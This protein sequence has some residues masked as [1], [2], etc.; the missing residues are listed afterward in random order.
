MGVGGNPQFRCRAWQAQILD[1]IHCAQLQEQPWNACE[2]TGRWKASLTCQQFRCYSFC[3]FLHR[4]EVARPT[5]RLLR[6]PFWV[7]IQN[8]MH[9]AS[10]LKGT[11]AMSA[12]SLGVKMLAYLHSFNVILLS[13]LSHRCCSTRRLL[14]PPFWNQV[15]REAITS[16]KSNRTAI[17][18][19]CTG[20]ITKM[21]MIIII[22]TV[23]CHAN[24]HLYYVNGKTGKLD[25]VAP[26][27]TR[28]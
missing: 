10:L 6:P 3:C 7:Q 21:M 18:A 2:V 25:N 9:C 11:L 27:H 28:D 15:R 8:V 22:I 13:C 12:R 14:R 1:V 16:H 24:L 23:W 26:K 17:W 19:L 4:L 5:C 20:Y